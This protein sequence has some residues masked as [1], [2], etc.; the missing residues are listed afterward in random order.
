MLNTSG[1]GKRFSRLTESPP[2][3]P[4]QKR[5]SEEYERCAVYLNPG[6]RK[7]LVAVLEAQLLARH[8]DALLE[9]GFDALVGTRGVGGCEEPTVPEEVPQGQTKGQRDFGFWL[10]GG[11]AS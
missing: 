2:F 1:G 4:S 11:A 10:G 6:T 8:R 9:K 3:P 7:P 5:L